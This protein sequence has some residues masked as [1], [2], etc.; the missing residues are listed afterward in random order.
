MRR[1]FPRDSSQSCVFLLVKAEDADR[2]EEHLRTEGFSRPSRLEDRKPA[3]RQEQLASEIKELDRKRE[4]LEKEL[5][6]FAEYREE[7]K[8]AS[9]Y[10]RAVWK[11]TKSWE[12]CF[13]RRRLSW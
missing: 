7:L 1:W 10:Y 3:D 6:S 13:S 2:L 12:I 5:I 4:A 11:N 9:D 8:L